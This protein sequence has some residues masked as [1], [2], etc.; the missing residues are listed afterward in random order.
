MELLRHRL[1]HFIASDAHDP[2]RRSPRL[3]AAYRK[4]YQMLSPQLADL[5]LVH[6][7]MAVLEDRP[8]RACPAF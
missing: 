1:V 7:P 2:I 8:I 3:L 6:N 4:V 5:L